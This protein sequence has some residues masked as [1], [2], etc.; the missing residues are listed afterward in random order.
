M[1]FKSFWLLGPDY[2]DS[3]SFNSSSPL[4]TRPSLRAS[5]PCETLSITYKRY[6]TSSI[7]ASSGIEEIARIASCL[8]DIIIRLLIQVSIKKIIQKLLQWRAIFDTKNGPQPH[9]LAQRKGMETCLITV[10]KRAPQFQSGFIIL[11]EIRI[12]ICTSKNAA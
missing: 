7:G 12:I 3:S 8:T 2:H 4:I 11:P 9:C 5:C 10:L 1:A 6:I